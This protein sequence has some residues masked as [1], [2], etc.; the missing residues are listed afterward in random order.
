VGCDHQKTL[1]LAG[2]VEPRVTLLVNLWSNHK[3]AG[4]ESLPSDIRRDLI[5]ASMR[6]SGEPP[7]CTDPRLTFQPL[8]VAEIAVSSAD[9][10]VSD[11]PL[12]LPFVSR[13]ATWSSTDDDADDY[14]ELYLSMLVPRHIKHSPFHTILFHFDAIYGPAL[15]P[16]DDHEDDECEGQER[17]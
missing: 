11:E 9:D 7:S 8:P 17:L 12:Y 10:L 16:K 14:E 1:P 5:A 2:D 15:L 6:S 13:N 4:V 3:P